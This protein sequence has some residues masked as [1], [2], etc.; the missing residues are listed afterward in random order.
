MRP[1]WVSLLK[2]WDPTNRGQIKAR[3]RS[4]VE[5][6]LTDLP[7]IP[8]KARY[9]GLENHLYR[10][11]VHKPGYAKGNSSDSRL[12]VSTSGQRGR[13][14]NS[15]SEDSLSSRVFKERATFKW[16]RDN[17]SVSFPIRKL[18]HDTV[19]IDNIWR[20]DR[21][22]LKE[23]DWV[24]AVDDDYALQNS[25]SDLFRIERIDLGNN[26]VKL[27]GDLNLSEYWE[28]KHPLLRRWDQKGDRNG[29]PIIEGTLNKFWFDLEA[30]IQIQFQPG[31]TY[32]TG[33]YWLIP[34][35][36]VTGDV[37]WPCQAGN[38]PHNHLM[39]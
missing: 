31:G 13:E 20:E 22:S 1:I 9:V 4:F 35:R 29:I 10:V 17:A 27:N 8:P 39:V 23:G 32:R 6:E 7:L 34:A 36:A 5:S 12:G 24:E 11:E 30:N 37:E 3:L 21:F 15:Q 14:T 2:K 33:D 18:T 26:E 16:S 25:A 19:T 38:P 28:A